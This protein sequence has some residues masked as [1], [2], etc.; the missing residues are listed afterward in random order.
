MAAEL[1]I[2]CPSLPSIGLRQL[3][4]ESVDRMI[5]LFSIWWEKLRTSLWPIPLVM[6]LPAILLYSTGVWI[7]GAHPLNEQALRSWFLHSGSGDDA[8]N[9]LTTLVTAIIT[10][11]SVVF[12]ITIVALS[13]AANQFGSRLIRI[14]ISDIRTKLALG[15]FVSTV[16]YCLLALRSLEKD[17]SSAEVPHITVTMGL[18]LGLICVLALLFF[19]HRIARSIIADEVIRRV[20]CELET[21]MSGLPPLRTRGRQ[22]LPDEVLPDDFDSLAIILT[23]RKEGYVQAVEYE[24]LVS[25]ASRHGIVLRLDF[26]PGTFMCMDG[27]LGAAYPSEAVTPEIVVAIQDRIV[28]GARRTPT[29]DL[30]FTI[31]HLVDIA[32]RALSPGINDANTALVVIER[33]RGALSRLMGKSLPM[34]ICRDDAGMI[35]IVTKGNS[36]AGIL[37]AALN[38]IRQAAA[39]QPAVI[40]HLLDALGR[41]AEHVRLPEQREALLHHARMIAAAGL[42]NLKEPQDRADIEE[43]LASAERKLDQALRGRLRVIEKSE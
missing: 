12:S 39:N 27:W 40:I 19:L 26:R 4:E 31:R 17:M 7:D 11:S 28:I 38:Q 30:E 13:L 20:A 15:F 34:G 5:S 10:M 41:M 36:H 21:H 24:R 35:R 16:V 42:Q 22:D 33:M 25:L 1:L 18:L 29:Q 3:P 37:D 8:R 2:G 14:Y 43:A 6:L 23:S 32:L 9:L